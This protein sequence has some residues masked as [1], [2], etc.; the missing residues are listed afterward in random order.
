M[1]GL[2]LVPAG[3][4]RTGL[5]AGLA[6]HLRRVFATEVVVTDLHLDLQACHDPMRRQYRTAP[7]MQQLLDAPLQGRVLA[8]TSVDLFIPVLTYVFG[9]AQVNGRVAVV[10]T[11]RLRPEVYGLPP[12]TGLL[13]ERLAKE[14]VHEL[15]HTFGLIHCAAPRCVIP[16]GAARPRS[17]RRGRRSRPGDGSPSG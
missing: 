13:A 12:D 3:L 14:S 4:P 11:H 15:G 9:E 17:R 7:I 1:S 5:V 10:S 8:V 6:A 16:P 2:S